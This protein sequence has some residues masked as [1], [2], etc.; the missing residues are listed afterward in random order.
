MENQAGRVVVGYDGSEPAQAALAW[1]ATEAQRRG[2]PL[3]VL[4]VLDYLGMIPSP[5]GPFG[6]PDVND[7][8]VAR[9]AKDGAE[10]AR[11][12][13]ESIDISAVTQV[14]Q[15]A[16]ALIDFSQRAELLVVGT[17]GHGEFAGAVLGSVGFA[18]SA[19]AHC[20]VVVV[21]GESNASLSGRPVVVGVDGS[22]GSDEAVRYGADVAASAHSPL[23]IV[24]A[25]QT[26]ASTVWA[27]ASYVDLEAKGGPVFDTVARESAHKVV[28]AAG[29]MARNAHPELTI[30]EQVV[31]GLPARVLASAA[32]GA[33]LLV[34]GS[35]G[36]GGFAGLLLGSVGHALIHNA[37]CPVTIM[38][39]S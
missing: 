13:A 17:R 9:I 33:G 38:H 8:D 29:E 28:A 1:A 22:S 21:R 11:K 7:E 2:H 25:Y 15:V 6:W 19:H 10:L 34:V 35:R 27:E 16:G 23:S 14:A 3:T 4:Y 18:V 12:S 5:M 36:H 20:P 31:E 26:L 24:S 39:S 30:T 32:D 37:P